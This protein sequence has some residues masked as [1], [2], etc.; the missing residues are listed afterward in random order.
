MIIGCAV[1]KRKPS[2]MW[3]HLAQDYAEA[4]VFGHAISIPSDRSSGCPPNDHGRPITAFSEYNTNTATPSVLAAKQP[5]CG[6][7]RLHPWG[8]VTVQAGPVRRGS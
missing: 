7:T 3:S 6:L 2:T 8:P 5:G 4:S 1:N